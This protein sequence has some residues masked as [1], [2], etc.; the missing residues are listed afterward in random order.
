MYDRCDGGHGSSSVDRQL[1]VCPV[2]GLVKITNAITTSYAR[3]SSSFAVWPFTCRNW[4]RPPQLDSWPNNAGVFSMKISE[5]LTIAKVVR[6]MI[7]CE[8]CIFHRPVIVLSMWRR[9]RQEQQLMLRFRAVWRTFRW[10]LPLDELVTRRWYGNLA[11]TSGGTVSI[12]RT[13]SKSLEIH[14]TAGSYTCVCV[15]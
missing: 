10:M 12:F 6:M 7:W 15:G 5:V 13:T 8:I 14:L 3:H 2:W 11:H 4:I 1:D 9:T